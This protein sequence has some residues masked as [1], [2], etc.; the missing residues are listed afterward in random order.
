[1]LLWFTTALWPTFVFSTLRKKEM[2]KCWGN[3]WP[4]YGKGYRTDKYIS[5]FMTTLLLWIAGAAIHGQ[6]NEPVK[7]SA[8]ISLCLDIKGCIRRR[9]SLPMDSLMK[10]RWQG[11]AA[12]HGLPMIIVSNIISLSVL[13]QHCLSQSFPTVHVSAAVSGLASFMA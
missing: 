6:V 12:W 2:P 3:W 4:Q 13:S 11:L 7:I 8:R 9:A 10:W 5:I 1:M